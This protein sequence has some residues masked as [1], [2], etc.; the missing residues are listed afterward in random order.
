MQSYMHRGCWI[1]NGWEMKSEDLTVDT[2]EVGIFGRRS[3]CD[4]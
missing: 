1:L 2:G 3:P 4:K